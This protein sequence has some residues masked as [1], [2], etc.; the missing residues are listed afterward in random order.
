MMT[1]R[2]LPRVMSRRLG[3]I[4]HLAF[5]PVASAAV[6]LIASVSV[7]PLPSIT[8]LVPVSVFTPPPFPDDLIEAVEDAKRLGLTP[9]RIGGHHTLA[10][11]VHLIRALRVRAARDATL[12]P[13]LALHHKAV[14]MLLPTDLTNVADNALEAVAV[15]L[16]RS[17]RHVL[18][19]VSPRAPSSVCLV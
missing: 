9:H 3:A 19:P 4:P 2:V 17:L 8:A 12:R 14:A 15:S 16:D 10:E 6:A 5:T 13:L 1:V 7:K 11:L 18:R